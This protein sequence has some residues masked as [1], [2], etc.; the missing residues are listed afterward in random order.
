MAMAGLGVAVERLPHLTTAVTSHS[1]KTPLRVRGAKSGTRL[2]S[3]EGEGSDYLVP[4]ARLIIDVLSSISPSLFVHFSSPS[5]ASKNRRKD[6]A[7]Y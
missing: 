2:W 6:K 7:A 3:L 1:R 4:V 5:A